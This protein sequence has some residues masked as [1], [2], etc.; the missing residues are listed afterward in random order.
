M[1]IALDAR[2]IYQPTRRGTGKNLIDLYTHLASAQPDWQVMAYHRMVNLKPNLNANQTRSLLPQSQVTPR[3]IEIMGD[4]YSA[5]ERVRLPMAAW[6]DGVSLLHC[7]ANTCPGWMPVPT[8]VTIHDLIPLDHPQG[9][10]PAQVKY[11]RQS[12]VTASQNAAGIICPSHYT[13]DRL[14]NEFNADPARI[15]V[16]HWAADSS[17]QYVEP[18]DRTAILKQYNL[19]D[20]QYVIHFG[21][22]APRKNTHRMIEAWAALDAKDR[23]QWKLL[24]V[25]LDNQTLARVNATII[26]HDLAS[27]V[28]A[29]GF[30]DEAHIPTLL[31]GSEILAFPSLSEGFGLPILDAWATKTAVL[32]SDC[33]SLPEVAQDAAVLIDPY[34]AGQIAAGLT[35]LM[36]DLTLRQQMI[37]R[38]SERL[39]VYTWQATTQRFIQAV[40]KAL[41]VQERAL[42]A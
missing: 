34:N 29:H 23:A 18:A 17:V 11:F 40:Q 7:P 16:N 14:V 9:R 15:T 41:N 31:S 6:R 26:S 35:E 24:I 32:T 1:R 13:R 4:R 19:H 25:G 33:T 8:L 3:H 10:D 38:G 42:A 39:N 20:S 12:I 27:S 37:E 22:S 21:A 36:R 30:A 28:K 5:W 2:T